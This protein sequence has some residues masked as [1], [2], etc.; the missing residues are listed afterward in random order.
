MHELDREMISHCTKLNVDE[1][2]VEFRDT[3]HRQAFF[4]GQEVFKLELV[5]LPFNSHFILQVVFRFQRNKTLRM[6]VKKM[7]DVFSYQTIHIGLLVPGSRILFE[8]S[9]ESKLQLTKMVNTELNFHASNMFDEDDSKN[10]FITVI[11]QSMSDG[12]FPEFVIQSS[13]IRLVR[14]MLLYG[15]IGTGKSSFAMQIGKMLNSI[16]TEIFHCS[17]ETSCWEKLKNQLQRMRHNIRNH[18]IVLILD[19]I[20]ELF[21]GNDYR[22]HEF[23]RNIDSLVD[24]EHLLVAI[25]NRMDRIPREMIRNGRFELQLEI[26]LPTIHGRIELLHTINGKMEYLKL[27]NNDNIDLSFWHYMIMC[28]TLLTANAWYGKKTQR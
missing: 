2:E 5:L 9:I 10:N 6:K 27:V 7:E 18:R 15:P 24:C 28:F 21:E 8:K 3:F 22:W 14:G 17:K 16:E 20:D 12:H 23:Y 1:L 11:K 13:G 25:T 4:V 26:T 19:R